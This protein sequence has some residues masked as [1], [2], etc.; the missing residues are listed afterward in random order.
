MSGVTS[1]SD[2]G[3]SGGKFSRAG[4]VTSKE[5]TGTSWE[6]TYFQA[7]LNLTSSGR[8][9][10][11]ETAGMNPWIPYADNYGTCNEFIPTTDMHAVTVLGEKDAHAG[12]SQ[13]ATSFGRVPV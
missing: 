2:L 10:N 9:L 8:M 3:H 5:V 7:M 13:P 4:V 6:G 12:R 1:Q 11:K